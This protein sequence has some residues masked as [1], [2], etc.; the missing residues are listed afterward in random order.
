MP[1]RALV[2]CVCCLVAG[3]AH[4]DRAVLRNGQVLE[5]RVRTLSGGEVEIRS[6]LGVLVLPAASIARVEHSVTLEEKVRGRLRADL[7]VSELWALAQECFEGGAETLG[8]RIL[9]RIVA[10]DPEHTAARHRLGYERRAGTW[11]PRAP[12]ELPKPDSRPT[13]G[14]LLVLRALLQPAPPAPPPPTDTRVFS[15]LQWPPT[16]VFVGPAAG[17]V[18]RPA[19]APPAST[20]PSPP[21]AAPQG[22]GPVPRRAFG[23]RPVNRGRFVRQR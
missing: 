3:A 21:A 8:R 11:V 4:A 18:P 19:G 15:P 17:L 2:F 10:I 5:G 13:A 14:E 12:A 23:P 7:T 16:G 1:N 22:P 6:E 9:E 20:A